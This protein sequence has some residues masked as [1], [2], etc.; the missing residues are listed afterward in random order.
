MARG[1][2]VQGVLIRPPAVNGPA[3][4]L[5]A[6]AAVSDF[7]T[8]IQSRMKTDAREALSSGIIPR[9]GQF[10]QNLAEITAG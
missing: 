3:R 7:V 6:A 9:E 5:R 2:E 10:K 4:W 1:V 8:S